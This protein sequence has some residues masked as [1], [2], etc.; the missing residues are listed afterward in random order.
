MDGKSPTGTDRHDYR[1]RE[2]TD[3]RGC[4][5]VTDILMIRGQNFKHFKISVGRSKLGMV[6]HCHISSEMDVR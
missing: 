4:V 2:S 6:G 1:Y 3:K 5:V